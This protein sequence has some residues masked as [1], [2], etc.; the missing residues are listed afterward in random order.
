[1]NKF[2]QWLLHRILGNSAVIVVHPS[3]VIVGSL[4]WPK[5]EKYMPKQ[6]IIASAMLTYFESHQDEIQV[7]FSEQLQKH[8]YKLN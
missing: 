3:G 5:T 2:K 7:W 1:M 6:S 4:F 8:K